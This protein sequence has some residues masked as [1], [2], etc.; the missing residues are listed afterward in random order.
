MEVDWRP[1]RFSMS[2]TEETRRMIETRW[3]E[4]VKENSRLYNASKFRLAGQR[5]EGGRLRLSL[6][7]TDYKD[8]LG[9]NLSPSAHLY[10]AEGE[11]EKYRHMAQCVGVGSWVLT[12]DSRLVMVENAGWKG[13]QERLYKN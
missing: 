4:A 5:L 3:A 1:E 11:E 9:T 7:L 12:T 2:E 13:E 8:H 6:G 10:V